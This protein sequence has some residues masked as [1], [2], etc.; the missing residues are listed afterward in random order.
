ANDGW[1]D[2][3]LERDAITYSP[4][5]WEMLGLEPGSAVATPGLRWELMHPED[6]QRAEYLLAKI[7]SS[8][9][10]KYEIEVRLRHQAGHYI[11][12]VSR[13]HIQRN[14]DG[15]AVRVSGTDLDIT[16]MRH[17][18][19]SANASKALL[20]AAGRI[21]RIGYWEIAFEGPSLFWS[22]IT[23]E[24][25]DLPPGTQVSLDDAMSF[26]PAEY[27]EQI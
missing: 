7:L 9:R 15:R 19:D 8:D 21:G 11:S 4:R 10:E 17:A 12:V 6:R 16:P 14:A 3:D 27:Q 25:H 24:I 2:W 23:A 22:D 5:W 13:G 26:F 20:E 1:W 18:F